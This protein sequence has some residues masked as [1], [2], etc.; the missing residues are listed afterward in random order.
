MIDEGF[1]WDYYLGNKRARL[2]LRKTCDRNVRDKTHVVQMSSA[3]TPTGRSQIPVDIVLIILD[4]LDKSDIATMCRLNKHF[5]AFSQPILFRDIRIHI[6]GIEDLYEGLSI[7][8]D[9][10]LALCETLSQ[11]PHLA[12]CVRSFSV[13]VIELYTTIATKIVETLEI[14]PSLRHLGLNVYDDFNH[15]LKGRTFSFKLE[16]FSFNLSYDTY[17]RDFLNSQPSLTT[18]DICFPASWENPRLEFD[19]RCLPNLTR[20]TTLFIDAEEIIRGRPVSEITCIGEPDVQYKPGQLR[21]LFPSL[22]HLTLTSRSR[23]SGMV[24]VRVSLCLLVRLFK[25]VI[26]RP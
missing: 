22:A 2:L 17:L 10:G 14:L 23:F 4:N 5:C 24:S 19:R 1:G 18:V 11:S 3:M 16:S 7:K 25:Y 20:V 9:R 13:R 6:R 12:R 8:H 26:G 15:L 21:E